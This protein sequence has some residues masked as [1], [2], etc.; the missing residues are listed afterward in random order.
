[1]STSTK[2]IF[3]IGILLVI[4]G[5]LCRLLNVY[6]F[7]DS[8][9]FGWAGIVAGVLAFLI[10]QRMARKAQKKNIFFVRLLVAVIILAAGIQ[11]GSIILLRNTSGYQ[12]A[13]ERIKDGQFKP[14][15]GAIRGIGLIPSGSDII[16]ILDPASSGSIVFVVTVRGEKAYRD[17]E[18]K[19]EG[20]SQMQWTVSSI[21]IVY[22]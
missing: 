6:F 4:Y 15:L 21:R 7:W 10:D 13:I 11:V 3:I 5:Y 16:N 12:E 22:I 20:G 14:E 8:K 2:V 1:M 17:V 9:H 19:M 18:I